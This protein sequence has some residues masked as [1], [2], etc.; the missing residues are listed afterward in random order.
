MNNKGKNTTLLLSFRQLIGPYSGS[1]MVEL[2]IQIIQ[3]YNLVDRIGYFVLDNATNNDTCLEKVFD[4]LCPDF[5]VLYQ[6]LCCF[7][8]VIN[9]A[10]KAFLYGKNP[11][12]FILEI[13][14]AYI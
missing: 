5:Q 4:Q 8:H 13:E 1:N 7:G 12:A 3:D 10:V 14:S 11:E 9:L 2:V 6:H